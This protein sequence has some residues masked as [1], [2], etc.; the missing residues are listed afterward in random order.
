[1]SDWRAR[2]TAAPQLNYRVLC[3]D[4]SCGQYRG[5]S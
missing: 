4:S 2:T 5:C 1:L 3:L